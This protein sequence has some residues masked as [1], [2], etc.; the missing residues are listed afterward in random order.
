MDTP[1]EITTD[2]K[3]LIVSP[4]EG[5]AREARFRKS[6]AKVNRKHSG[7]LKKLAE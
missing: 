2:G 5:T 6:L 4:V 1:L 7:T 3:S